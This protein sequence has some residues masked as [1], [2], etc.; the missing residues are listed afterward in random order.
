VALASV[1]GRTEASTV[2]RDARGSVVMLLSV[3]VGWADL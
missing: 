3:A 2:D 1:A